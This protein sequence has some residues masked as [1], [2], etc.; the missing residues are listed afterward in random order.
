M[1]L[2]KW[3]TILRDAGNAVY[4]AF[5]W[6]G[7]YGLMQLS[8]LKPGIVANISA[9]GND[10]TAVVILSLIYWFL[11]VVLGT[12]LV[13]MYRDVARIVT[14]A[15]HTIAFRI[16][17]EVGNVK[18]RLVCKLRQ[19]LSWV[20]SRP[21]PETPIVE[22]DKLDLA[23]MKSAV[24]KGPG[25]ALSAPEL[26]EQFALRPA[27]VQRSLDKLCRNSMITSV[28]GSTEG[29]DNYHLTDS[30]TAFVAMWDRQQ[31]RAAASAGSRTL[32]V[33]Q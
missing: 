21:D 5:A 20:R 11:V 31:P 10:T 26:A 13:R 9:Q 12:L 17:L 32:A 30:G 24:A 7:H 29:F 14:A 1:N 6:P 33:P 15:A 4:D 27:Q 2:E 19:R 23:I 8:V 16:S 22:F 3:L 28:I 25:F 18:T